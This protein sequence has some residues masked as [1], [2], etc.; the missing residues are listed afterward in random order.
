MNCIVNKEHIVNRDFTNTD[1]CLQSLLLFA[2][3]LQGVP[4][5]MTVGE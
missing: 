5:N 2:M 3:K 1:P 4:R